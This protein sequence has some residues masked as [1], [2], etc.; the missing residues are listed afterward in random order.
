MADQPCPVCG[1]ETKPKYYGPF[2]TP[3]P[4][5]RVAYTCPSGDWRGPMRET[6]DAAAIVAA[7]GAD[8]SWATDGGE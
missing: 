4:V 5:Y 8:G 6:I 1:S 3:T 2:F 7:L